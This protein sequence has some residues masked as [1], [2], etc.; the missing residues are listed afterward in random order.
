[1]NLNFSISAYRKFY[2]L[3]CT[4]NFI[5]IYSDSYSWN[6]VLTPGN[7]TSLLPENAA[8]LE[9]R[10]EAL[11]KKAKEYHRELETLTVRKQLSG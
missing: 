8:T 7:P 11:I 6:E 10:K 2:E 1:M 3:C 5:S 9:R 4:S